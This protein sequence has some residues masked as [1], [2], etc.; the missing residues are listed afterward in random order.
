M[1]RGERRGRVGGGWGGGVVERVGRLLE[2]L[3]SG[4]KERSTGA[5]EREGRGRGGREKHFIL[6]IILTLKVELNMEGFIHSF[7]HSFN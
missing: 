3:T 1:R 6:T 5:K 7:V 2:G 4:H